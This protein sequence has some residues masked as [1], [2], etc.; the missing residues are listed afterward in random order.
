MNAQ[1]IATF[2]VKNVSWFVPIPLLVGIFRRKYLVRE[3]LIIFL[4][5]CNGVLFELISRT[6]AYYSIPNLYLF[7]IYVLMEFLFISWFYYEIFKRYISPKI[8]PTIFIFFT[9]F[10]LIDSFFLHNT[11]TFNS[12]AKTA[13]CLIIVGY[14][15]FYLY[16]TFDEFQDQDPSDTPVFWINAGFLFYFSGCLFLFTFSNFILTQGKPMGMIT[17]ALHAFFIVI[18]YSLISIGLW[19]STAK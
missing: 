16:K 8:I 10:S 12:Y 2:I 3:L 19:R 14:T 11:L 7:H 13:E 1:E 4:Y 17:W 15:A 6:M 18:M 5:L 9:I